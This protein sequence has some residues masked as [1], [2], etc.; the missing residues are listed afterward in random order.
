MLALRRVAAKR[1]AAL[2]TPF[3][4]APFSSDSWKDKERAAESSYFNKEDEKA[5]RKLLKK[6]KGQADVNDE[7]GLKDHVKHDTEGLKKLG[8]D[9]SKEQVAAL[10]KWKHEH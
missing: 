1:S 3:Q 6:L 9:L 10:L 7:S 5:L 4:T 8:L 2:A